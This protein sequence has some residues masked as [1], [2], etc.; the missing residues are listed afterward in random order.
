[1]V[2]PLLHHA[3]YN[4]LLR[5]WKAC[6][7]L[8]S[9]QKED[10]LFLGKVD[11]GIAVSAQGF[12]ESSKAPKPWVLLESN[13]RA[14]RAALIFPSLVSQLVLLVC[15]A[16]EPDTEEEGMEGN[17]I[18]LDFSIRNKNSLLHSALQLTRSFHHHYLLLKKF[19]A[20]FIEYQCCHYLHKTSVPITMEYLV[21]SERRELPLESYK[22]SILMN[23]GKIT[24]YKGHRPLA[25]TKV[26]L[27]TRLLRWFSLKGYFPHY[28]H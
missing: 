3:V 19:M 7:R 15:I 21:R 27:I 8:R 6:G 17:D 25:W 28:L 10:V 24:D 4:N 13:L 26:M 23:F 18:C 22:I 9:E 11:N 14:D 2:K 5:S 16:S 20:H 12:S 1:M